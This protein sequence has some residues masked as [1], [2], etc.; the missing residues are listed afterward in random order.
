MVGRALDFCGGF[1]ADQMLSLAEAAHLAGVTVEDLR[2]RIESG[3]I[4]GHIVEE[5]DRRLPAI[6]RNELA[7][8]FPA[9]YPHPG[10][11]TPPDAPAAPQVRALE[12]DLARAQVANARLEGELATS[13]KV[14]RATQRYADKLESKLEV[15]GRDKLAL[16]RA[17]GQ[18][19]SRIA[20]L[21]R[22][23]QELPAPSV[24]WWR[25]L[26]GRRS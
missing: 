6:T 12:R 15:A 20:S 1:G 9:S 16:A 23:L 13:A 14:E 3:P 7:R 21:E 18:A 2:Q 24:S 17:L 8:H 11:V 26:S 5:G 19:E 10:R 4:E 25:R 22:R